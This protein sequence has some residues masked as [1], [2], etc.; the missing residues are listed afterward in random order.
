MGRRPKG[1]VKQTAEERR[2]RQ[3]QCKQKQRQNMRLVRLAT[4]RDKNLS[5][6]GAEQPE[7]QRAAWRERQRKSR[8]KAAAARAA[9]TKMSS[10]ESMVGSSTSR[11]SLSKVTPHAP[12]SQGSDS[13]PPHAPFQ[14][15][16]SAPPHAPPGD[17]GTQLLDSEIVR[18]QTIGIPQILGSSAHLPKA[19]LQIG[20]QGSGRKRRVGFGGRTRP[21]PPGNTSPTT[22]GQTPTSMQEIMVNHV[23][24][25]A[26]C[27]SL[28]CRRCVVPASLRLRCCQCCFLP[29]L[30][31][32]RPPHQVHC[33]IVASRPGGGCLRS[34]TVLF[35]LRCDAAQM[36]PPA[37]VAVHTPPPPSL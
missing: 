24:T 3:R 21:P 26:V 11:T 10:S 25:L 27:L 4:S 29:L 13:A 5:C 15:S 1:L 23:S 30:Q 9:P 19:R 33:T 2:A 18:N 7:V 35:L 28:V 37:A 16:D 22:A 20:G 34:R 17:N 36:L 6:E 32:T 31:C 14:R 8:A 12:P